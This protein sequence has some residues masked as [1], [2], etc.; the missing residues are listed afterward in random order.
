MFAHR[1]LACRRAAV[2]LALVSVASVAET[3]TA[4]SAALQGFLPSLPGWTMAKPELLDQTAMGTTVSQALA[5]YSD[6]SGNRVRVSLI[7]SPSVV[8]ASRAMGMAFRNEQMVTMMN[9]NAA[10]KGKRVTYGLLG[11]EGWQG[12][13]VVNGDEGTA[14]ATGMTEQLVVKIETTTAQAEILDAFLDAINWSE[15]LALTPGTPEGP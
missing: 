2:L 5:D 13:T 1:A 9:Q 8:A 7:A 6:A 15:L 14:E 4:R 10:A 11:R 12:W 3:Q